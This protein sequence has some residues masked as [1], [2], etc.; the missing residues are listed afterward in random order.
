MDIYDQLKTDKIVRPFLQQL[1][2]MRDLI[3]SEF[4]VT[5]MPLL[6]G[7]LFIIKRLTVSKLESKIFK[8]KL[9][10]CDTQRLIVVLVPKSLAAHNANS[11]YLN[12]G[13]V[14]VPNQFFIAK[15][16][17]GE[18]G[19]GLSP[20]VCFHA[21]SV[22]V[23]S[24]PAIPVNKFAQNV[25]FNSLTQTLLTCDPL[26]KSE[27]SDN[28]VNVNSPS[29]IGLLM[30]QNDNEDGKSPSDSEAKMVEIEISGESLTCKTVV[31]DTPLRVSRSNN[32]DELT[33]SCKNVLAVPAGNSDNVGNVDNSSETRKTE[34]VDSRTIDTK[35]QRPI[36]ASASA[37]N[38]DI[39]RSNKESIEKRN[40]VCKENN[41]DKDF[42]NRSEI[43]QSSE[44]NQ[45][46]WSTNSLS[47]Q[48]SE[49]KN[50][51]SGALVNSS[52]CPQI[53]QR[54]AS[55]PVDPGFKGPR[56]VMKQT[57]NE[58]QF[59]DVQFNDVHLMKCET[60]ADGGSGLKKLSRRSSELLYDD[61]YALVMSRNRTRSKS[62]EQDS[63]SGSGN[64]SN[65]FSK[66]GDLGK[67]LLITPSNQDKSSQRS[68]NFSGKLKTKKIGDGD[69]AQKS[70]EC[71]R[72]MQEANVT[73]IVES[74]EQNCATFSRDDKLYKSNMPNKILENSELGHLNSCLA[75]VEKMHLKD[76]SELND[77][78][79]L[80]PDTGLR[81]ISNKQG[82]E[83]N[84]SFKNLISQT[85]TQNAILRAAENSDNNSKAVKR[86]GPYSRSKAAKKLRGNDNTEIMMILRCRAIDFVGNENQ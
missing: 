56:E 66:S 52:Q 83:F 5:Q 16:F 43:A 28:L 41:F 73:Y 51:C 53:L 86:K 70:S 26:I 17:V 18:P 12:S 15:C 9:L 13:W 81:A 72:L 82:R 76:I 50:S 30:R 14:F 34:S 84:A 63:L 22:T 4:V 3:T 47:K 1:F 60:N 35:A 80:E 31:I 2:A 7:S 78:K 58:L 67:F 32:V 49:A 11:P 19:E 25:V 65:N 69:E 29:Q 24:S 23:T 46:Q 20:T 57:H 71:E 75:T 10:C 8:F 36:K 27:D 6:H 79:E 55:V 38:E 62:K 40:S 21:L 39:G 33:T 61:Y 77:N 68:E 54:S 45:K 59:N 48:T 37:G 74:R 64:S 85:V 42:K 44:K